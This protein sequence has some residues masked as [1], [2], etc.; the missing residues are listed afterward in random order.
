MIDHAADHFKK[1]S[2]RF[3][4]KT[5]QPTNNHQKLRRRPDEPCAITE[6]SPAR[7]RRI[8]KMC[9]SAAEDFE[10]SSGREL[11]I[12]ENLRPS[13]QRFSEKSGSRAGNFPKRSAPTHLHN[14]GPPLQKN[15][16]P[17]SPHG[18]PCKKIT[19]TRFD[20]HKAG[21]PLLIPVSGPALPLKLQAR[22]D[23]GSPFPQ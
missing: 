10:K 21:P 6:K 17:P 14:Q 19:R 5:G 18:G 7:Q 3:F 16:R 15:R 9:Y 13:S 8:L 20:Q 22:G 1:R 12:P 23:R 4:P 11:R 2:P